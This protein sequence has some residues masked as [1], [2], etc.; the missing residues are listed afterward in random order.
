ML[1]A[2]EQA[3]IMST[4]HQFFPCCKAHGKTINKKD[5]FTNWLQ[6]KSTYIT[7]I[8]CCMTNKKNCL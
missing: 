3:K 2:L 5:L 8:L 6:I 4:E 7:Q 1:L